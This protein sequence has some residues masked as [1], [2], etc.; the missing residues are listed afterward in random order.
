MITRVSGGNARQAATLGTK[1]F[2]FDSI[3]V[4]KLKIHLRLGK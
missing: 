3:N 4:F 1:F 2:G